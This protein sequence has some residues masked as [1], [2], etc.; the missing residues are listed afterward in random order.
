MTVEDAVRILSD[1]GLDIDE[2]TILSTI[3]EYVVK[4][5]KDYCISGIVLIEERNGMGGAFRMKVDL[6]T[7]AIVMVE[8]IAKQCHNNSIRVFLHT[9][10]KEDALV[11]LQNKLEEGEVL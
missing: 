11:R 1:D 6:E 5:C 10:Q 3:N 8:A 7:K 2:E 4:W 9:K